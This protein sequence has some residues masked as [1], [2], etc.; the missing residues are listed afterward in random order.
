MLP[1][2][3]LAL[4]RSSANAPSAAA[5]IM[6]FIYQ[7]CC[8][9]YDSSAVTCPCAAWRKL[10]LFLDSSRVVYVGGMSLTLCCVCPAFSRSRSLSLA[11]AL[12]FSLCVCVWGGG[13]AAL[14]FTKS[15]PS[16]EDDVA[17][18]AHKEAHRRVGVYCCPGYVQGI[19]SRYV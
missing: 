4:W 8:W 11:R 2:L 12:S 14:S 10:S 5:G 9:H 16:G 7:Y 6:A 18:L 1:M 19:L 13:Y 3:L 15:A 17:S